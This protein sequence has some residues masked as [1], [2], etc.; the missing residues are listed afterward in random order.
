MSP[1]GALLGAPAGRSASRVGATF[2]PDG[3]DVKREEMICVVFGLEAVD[4][5]VGMWVGRD[6]PAVGEGCARTIGAD[7][8]VD[9]VAVLAGDVT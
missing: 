5:G 2:G 8:G 7:A 3:P 6:G 4:C 1:N 9:R